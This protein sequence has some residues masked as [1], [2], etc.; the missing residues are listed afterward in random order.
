VSD[1]ARLTDQPPRYVPIAEAAAYARVPASTI[2]DWIR[3][4]LLPGYR[5]GPRL[6]Q[7]NLDDIDSLRRRVPTIHRTARR[8]KR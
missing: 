7:V 4:G 1:T 2:R 8:N 6:L 5:L 3:R